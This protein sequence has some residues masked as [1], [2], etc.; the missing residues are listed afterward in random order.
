MAQVN[1]GGCVVD[2]RTAAELLRIIKEIPEDRR[3]G[4]LD[5]LKDPELYK[6][7]K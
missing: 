2:T 5:A 4:F 3:A 6:D 7:E 1:I